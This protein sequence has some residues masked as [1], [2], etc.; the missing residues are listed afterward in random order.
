VTGG[1]AAGGGGISAT[2][3]A[4]IGAAVGGGAV[5]ATQVTKSDENGGGGDHYSG[6]FSAPF[7][8]VNVGAGSTCTFNRTMSGTVTID[9]HS[10]G[11][12]LARVSGTMT[13]AGF[14]GSCVAENT[15]NF[16]VPDGA[17][18]G[19]PSAITFT[20]ANSDLPI[21]KATFTGSLS[22]STITGQLTIEETTQTATGGQTFGGRGT[23]TATVTLTK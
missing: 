4:I 13:P 12:G 1:A 23:G 5:V 7:V 16:S 22:G 21:T 8:F 10:D 9:L 3:I 6:P 11:T 14:I 19:G 2:T 20:A 17:V 15:R 18:T